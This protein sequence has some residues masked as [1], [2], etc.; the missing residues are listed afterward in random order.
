M[1]VFQVPFGDKKS[2]GHTGGID[3]FQSNA[4]LFPTERVSIAYISN[5][6]TMPVNDIL[7]GVLSIYFG[8]S[9]DLPVF[10]DALHLKSEELDKYLGIY[11]SLSFPLKITITKEKNVLIAQATGQPS[12]SLE[13]YEEHKFKFDQALLKLEFIPSESKMILRQGGSEFILER[14]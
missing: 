1:G 11:S 12:F 3:G 4:F 9:Y 7:I 8:K 10:T 2:F 5:G 13:A 14:E 6:V